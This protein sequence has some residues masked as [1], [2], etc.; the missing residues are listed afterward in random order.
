VAPENSP[1]IKR[2]FCAHPA[3]RVP[4]HLLRKKLQDSSKCNAVQTQ[5]I[6]SRA[7]QSSFPSSDGEGQGAEVAVEESGEEV[8]EAPR[9]LLD[10]EQT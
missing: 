9:G 2:R 10:Q 3:P 4:K 6:S 1:A 5:R 8:V 7:Y